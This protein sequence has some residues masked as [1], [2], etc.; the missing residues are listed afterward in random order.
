MSGVQ[1]DGGY[2]WRELLKASKKKK[3]KDD[4]VRSSFLKGRV[5]P[6]IMRKVMS[7]RRGSNRL[8]PELL[9]PFFFFFLCF[10]HLQPRSYSIC[11]DW[12]FAWPCCRGLWATSKATRRPFMSPPH[13]HHHHHVCMQTY[14][15]FSTHTLFS[16]ML[17]HRCK[18]H[19]DTHTHTHT[20]TW[21]TAALSL[22][23][24]R[25]PNGSRACW[26]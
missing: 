24:S 11:I 7:R 2:L 23:L 6:S 10:V 3:K 22:S 19:S 12:W 16:Q 15:Q 25:L 9:L 21:C 5:W 26:V 18:A 8:Q 20:H 13:H 4:G 14:F 1:A 17:T